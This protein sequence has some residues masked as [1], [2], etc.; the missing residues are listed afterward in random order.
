MDTAYAKTSARE[1]FMIRKKM[2]IHKNLYDSMLVDLAILLIDTA[3]IHR[4]SFGIE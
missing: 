3:I 1:T 2:V 4:K